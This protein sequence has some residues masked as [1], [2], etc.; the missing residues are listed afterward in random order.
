[1]TKKTYIFCNFTLKSI[2]FI[3]VKIREILAKL[4]Y[5]TGIVTL[6]LNE[7]VNVRTVHELILNRLKVVKFAPDVGSVCLR[8]LL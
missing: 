3:N 2:D 1:M 5:L 8:S 6:H 7:M 4:C